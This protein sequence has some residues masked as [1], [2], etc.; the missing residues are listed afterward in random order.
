M[1]TTTIHPRAAILLT[2]LSGAGKTTLSRSLIRRLSEYGI[3]DVVLLDGDEVRERLTRPHGHSIEERKSVWR[4]IVTLARKELAGGKVVVI[5][6]IAHLASMRAEGRRVLQPFFEVHLECPVEIC[7]ARDNKGHYAR[8]FASEYDCFIGVTHPYERTDDVDLRINTASLLAGEAE[9]LLV[10]SVVEF[11]SRP[12]K[13]PLTLLARLMRWHRKFRNA[14][15]ISANAA[16]RPY[17]RFVWRL[18][19]SRASRAKSV[20][21][22]GRPSCAQLFFLFGGMDGFVGTSGM[23]TGMS[24]LDFFRTSGLFSR[25]LVWIRDPYGANFE[26]GISPEV[27]DTAGLVDWINS[28]RRSLPHVTETHA[29]G[30]SSGCYGALMLGH[31]C[32]MQSVWVFGPRTGRPKG[33]AAAKERLRNLLSVHNGVTQYHVWYSVQNERDEAFAKLL[34]NC[35]GVT[36]H[37]YSESGDEHALLRYLAEQELLK[38]ILPSFVPAVGRN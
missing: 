5:A 22:I 37:A 26:R 35:P 1:I 27:P 2:G 8:A 3:Q 6:T 9:T 18:A 14:R 29:V 11:L 16:E 31:V 20:V 15:P 23:I 17:L 13:R 10:R 36:L 32:K 19:L 28:H 12:V 33:A 30:Y 34:A 38:S 7:A 25:N 21:S 4:E 24:P